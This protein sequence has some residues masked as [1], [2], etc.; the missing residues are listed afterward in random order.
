MFILGKFGC[1]T[2]FAIVYVYTVEMYPTVVR[3]TGLGM[4]SMVARIGGI[5]APQVNP[6]QHQLCFIAYLTN[7]N[8]TTLYCIQYTR[9]HQK[10]AEF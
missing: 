4:C 9:F 2:A 8:E 7:F 1:S 10:N 5:A 3:T 6:K